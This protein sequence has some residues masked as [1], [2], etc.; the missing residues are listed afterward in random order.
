MRPETVFEF[1]IR[2]AQG[3][4]GVDVQMAREVDTGKKHITELLHGPL[5][6]P[7]LRHGGLQLTEFFTQFWQ[8]T[9]GI[10]P[11]EAL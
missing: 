6:P 3:L 7:G 9:G 1:R 8:H 5:M 4:V 11:V 10:A 2:P